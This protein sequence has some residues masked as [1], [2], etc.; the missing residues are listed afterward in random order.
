MACYKC[1]CKDDIMYEC[2]VEKC[3]RMCCYKHSREAVLS[4]GR[5]VVCLGCYDSRQ[6]SIKLGNSKTKS[7]RKLTFH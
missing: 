1:L 3:K 2:G 4:Y 5:V 7:K 6:N